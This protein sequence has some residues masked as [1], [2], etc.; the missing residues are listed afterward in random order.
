V[1]GRSAIELDR[2]GIDSKLRGRVALVTGAAGSI[3]SELC[4]QIAACEP[5]AL[6]ALD[7]AETPLFH[8]EREL[9]QA[10]PKLTIHSVIASVQNVQRLHDVFCRY[11]PNV[12]YHAAAYKHVP[13]MEASLFEAIEN[14]V[15]GT[16]NVAVAAAEYEVDDFVM[17]SSDKAVRPTNIMG[18]TK[19]HGGACDPIAPEWRSAL[20]FGSF[21]KRPGQQRQRGA[22]LQGTNRCRWP[23]HRHASRD[24]PILHDDP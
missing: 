12:V 5:D 22:H 15:L 2:A 10:F 18:A 3:G 13:M 17:I 19:A 16:Y 6:V 9:R 11:R 4:R 23:G 1:L 7:I 20:R 14:N 24:A 21:W 8:L